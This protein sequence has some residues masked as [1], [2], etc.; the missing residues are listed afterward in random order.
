MSRRRSSTRAQTSRFVSTATVVAT[1]AP[2][3]TEDAHQLALER[4]SARAAER[5]L[6]TSLNTGGT[7]HEPRTTRASTCEGRHR[8][9]FSVIPPPVM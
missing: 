1:P 4:R 7:F 8:S 9:R 2:R 5:E 6:A 3:G